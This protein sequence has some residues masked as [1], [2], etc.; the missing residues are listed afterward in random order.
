M[1]PTAYS[2]WGALCPKAEAFPSEGGADCPTVCEKGTQSFYTHFWL[3]D[4]DHGSKRKQRLGG[5]EVGGNLSGWQAQMTEATS[6]V[7]AGGLGVTSTDGMAGVCTLLWR[8][9]AG[10]IGL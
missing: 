5:P 4:R 6:I 10:R 8:H 2:R 3:G 7:R 9:R 1:H